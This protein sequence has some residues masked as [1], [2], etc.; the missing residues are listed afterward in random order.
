MKHTKALE[1]VDL[2]LEIQ[3]ITTVLDPLIEEGRAEFEEFTSSLNEILEKVFPTYTVVISGP[4]GSGKSTLL[5]SLLQEAGSHP[6]ASIGPSNETFAPMSISFSKHA[7]LIVWYFGIDILHT[8][9]EQLT[10][11][12]R[13]GDHSHLVAQYRDIRN[14]LRQIPAVLAGEKGR[15]VVKRIS[16]DGLNR[17]TTTDTIRSYTAQSSSLPD[18]YGIYRAEIT[19]PGRILRDL[20]NVRF[21]DLFGFGEPSPLINIKYSRFISEKFPDAV[22]YVFPDRSITQDFLKLFEI[23]SFIEKIVKKGRLFLVL[24]K[25]DAYTDSN[26]NRWPA[27]VAQFRAAIAHHVPA[28]SKLV[29]EIPIF[30]L[31]A[32]SIDSTIQHIEAR[33]IRDASLSS[34]HHLRDKIRDLSDDLEDSSSDP[35][36]YLGSLFDLM[37]TLDLL[38]CGVELSLDQIEARIPSISGLIGDISNRQT[39]FEDERV[40]R[41]DVFRATL[42]NELV[43][44]LADIDYENTVLFNM[45]ECEP[46]HPER[47]FG[48]M[49]E[50]AH[51]GAMQVFNYKLSKILS[52]IGDL[53]DDHLLRAYREYVLL[54]D[55]AAKAESS[56]ISGI[57][58]T[59][60]KP[61]SSTVEHAAKDFVRFTNNPQLHLSAKTIFEKFSNWYLRK[62]C[63][64]NAERG[65]NVST[66][67]NQIY[68]NVEKA[69]ETFMLVYVCE[70][71][72]L[73]KSYLPH[74]CFGGVPTLW[75]QLVKHVTGLDELL[76]NQIRITKWRFGLYQNRRFFV[77]NRPEYNRTAHELLSKKQQAEELI[78]KLA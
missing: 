46:N 18:V 32:A 1:L 6:I 72:Q 36:V 33:H 52:E 22:V 16:L 54:Q 44:H 64:W 55:K 69:I 49:V 50:S 40:S 63:V 34:L 8:I 24:N 39:S 25:A 43:K 26:V 47:L 66:I 77:S 35:S 13:E 5:S 65:Q 11:F 7:N 58:D 42:E 3:R 68:L 59:T 61:L 12:E 17:D 4:V 75:E 37:K 41:L 14:R 15:E 71:K 9:E 67:K 38:V 57:S 29:H 78:I 76:A 21:T 60:F 62:R 51:L 53:V 10:S 45:S 23:Q 30:I 73:T 74:I 56:T 27:V 20:R 28:L 31:S 19:Y 70:D 48:W 2:L